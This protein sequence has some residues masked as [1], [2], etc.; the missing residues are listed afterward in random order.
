MKTEQGVVKE[1]D[2]EGEE[3]TSRRGKGAEGDI[4]SK[5]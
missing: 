5:Y 2:K 1:S 4:H 3:Q